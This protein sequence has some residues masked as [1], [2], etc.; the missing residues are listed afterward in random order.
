MNLTELH[1]IL[2]ELCSSDKETQWLEFKQNGID[3][4]EIGEY[5]SALSNGACIDNK[6]HG[7]LIWGVN[8]TTHEITGTTF[9]ISSS[10]H[11]NQDLELWLRTFL[12]PKVHFEIFEFDYNGKAVTMLKIP[13][14]VAEPTHFQKKPFIRINSNK[15]DLRNHPA[16]IRKI[17]N[18]QE[19]WSAKICK[20]ASLKTLILQPFNLHE[21]A[22]E[23]KM[24]STDQRFLSGMQAHY[25]TG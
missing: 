6:L 9:K 4:E 20:E 8:N 11:G 7:Y 21:L 5:I 14:A 13:S 23:R 1:T 2:K 17:Y 10:K 22:M 3:H 12:H 24:K 18:S 15:T 25:W 16:L 19:D